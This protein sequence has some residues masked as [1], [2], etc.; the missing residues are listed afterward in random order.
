MASAHRLPSQGPASGAGREV[1][2]NPDAGDP[3][4]PVTEWLITR[5][6]LQR[7]AR[8]LEIAAGSG[9]V[10]F[11]AA[12]HAPE[13][14]YVCTDVNVDALSA[15][16]AHRASWTSEAAH[17]QGR[18]PSIA[19]LA[20]DMRHLP[21]ATGAFDAALCRMGFMFAPDPTAAF[22]E[23][24][25]VLRPGGT[26]AFAV[27]GPPDQNPW[28]SHLDEALASFGVEDRSAERWPEGMFGLGDEETLHRN[29]EEAGFSVAEQAGVRV[30]RQYRSF[31]EYWAREVDV[32][33]VRQIRLRA[34][35]AEVV[36]AFHARL[37]AAISPY[38]KRSGYRIPSL[39][40]AMVAY[41]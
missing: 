5:V 34:L 21:F 10:T 27:W 2:S 15:A 28:Q 36:S 9:T 7:G 19:F 26:L 39:S 25:R 22:R 32:G 23:A 14:T 40:L 3:G 33:F 13:A 41:A 8:V 31:D 30:Q 35:G 1:T 4:R 6:P 17:A 38:R 16:A 29:L 24:R 20:A 18:V 11:A 37:E 12:A